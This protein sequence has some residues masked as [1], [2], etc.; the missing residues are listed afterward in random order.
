MGGSISPEPWLPLSSFNYFSQDSEIFVS[1]SVSS[2]LS[3]SALT[4]AH[5]LA[6]SS[7]S[8]SN[9]LGTL[10]WGSRSP[11]CGK[12]DL[13]HLFFIFW[14]H[15]LHFLPEGGG[16]GG[17]AAWLHPFPHS[18]QNQSPPLQPCSWEDK[19]GLSLRSDS[20]IRRLSPGPDSWSSL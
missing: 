12:P 10:P 16:G 7:V 8:A 4:L 19:L 17:A 20:G 18:F 2:C 5:S 15:Q 3:I 1:L 6:L 13:H 9:V 14:K 11:V